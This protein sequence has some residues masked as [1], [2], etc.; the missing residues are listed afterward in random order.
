MKRLYRRKILQAVML[1]LKSGEWPFGVKEIE[2]PWT[3]WMLQAKLGSDQ[4]LQQLH[5]DSTTPTS[6]DIHKGEV[7]KGE[8]IW[9]PKAIALAANADLARLGLEEVS[10]LNPSNSGPGIQLKMRWMLN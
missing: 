6:W 2:L 9:K 7:R 8:N 4:H 5:R 1:P 10:G 3:G